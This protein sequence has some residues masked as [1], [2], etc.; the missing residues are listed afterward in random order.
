[1]NNVA[2]AIT[3]HV[4]IYEAALNYLPEK[5]TNK[6][7][8]DAMLGTTY[9]FHSSFVQ[10]TVYKMNNKV[11]PVDENGKA[12]S[13][14]PLCSYF[15][16]VYDGFVSSRDVNRVYD[17]RLCPMNRNVDAPY[18]TY[19]APN[20]VYFCGLDEVVSALRYINV[21]S[22]FLDGRLEYNKVRYG[23]IRLRKALQSYITSLREVLGMYTSHPIDTQVDFLLGM[24]SSAVSLYKGD[25][26]KPV[27]EVL[28][29]L[30]QSTH[31]VYMDMMY[32]S[33]STEDDSA[34]LED[35]NKCINDHFVDYDIGS[36]RNELLSTQLHCILIQHFPERTKHPD[37]Y[38]FGYLTTLD[39]KDWSK[40]KLQHIF[41]SVKTKP[42]HYEVA[43][44]SIY[45]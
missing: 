17:C 23:F 31:P 35:I 36:G 37:R 11:I 42:N 40:G 32:Y 28:H 13:L 6:W 21:A 30:F 38:K 10:H 8:Y 44:F 26:P 33:R 18:S 29:S 14:T 7:I 19:S 1:M 3:D 41:V 12:K 45:T 22:L 34:L 43:V 27:R 16:E 20:V 15:Q 9:R 24:L 39:R 5:F 25:E 4:A 2:Q